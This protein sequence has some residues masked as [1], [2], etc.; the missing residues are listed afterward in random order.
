MATKGLSDNAKQIFYFVKDAADKG[1]NI[2]AADIA[3]GLDMG[4][5]SVN[6]IINFTFSKNGVMG[7][8]E[9]IVEGEDG[10]NKTIKFIKL[11]D[12]NFDPEYV[13]E[14]E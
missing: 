5:R 12:R 14:A 7:R 6:A 1:I 11:L 13:P 8:E 9:A 2:T 10:K 4:V 3:N